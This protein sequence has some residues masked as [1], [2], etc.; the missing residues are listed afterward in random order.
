MDTPMAV[1]FKCCKDLSGLQTWY[2]LHVNCFAEWFKTNENFKNL[3]LRKEK[4]DET[5]DDSL[6]N[7]SFFHGQFEK[8]SATL[9]G[10][11][12]ILKISQDYPELAKTEYLCNQLG[13][14]LGL[15]LPPYFLISFEGQDCFVSYNFMQ[16]YRGADLKHIYHFL[17]PKEHMV[18]SLVKVIETQTGRLSEVKKF[19]RLCLFDAF[20]G[21][22]DRH[23]RNLALV[24]THA[25]CIFSPCYDNPSFIARL[26]D[27]LLGADLNVTGVIATSASQE[28]GIQEYGE[29]FIRLG[30]KDVLEDFVRAIDMPQLES[31]IHNSFI[32][33]KRKIAF[34]NFIHK[35]YRDLQ[36]V[37]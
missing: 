19:I 23:G 1:C 36:N 15:E 28:P 24:F 8:Y 21:N 33:A 16:D 5:P 20:T 7:E 10:E 18:E 17:K 6:P 3:T 29:E 26:E 32:S 4:P 22:D 34:I 9:V 37:L 31:L 11:Q 14:S 30:Y 35:K 2:G 25:S 13:E 27:W 12:Y